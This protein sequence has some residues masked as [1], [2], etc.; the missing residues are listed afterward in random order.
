MFSVFVD[1]LTVQEPG[2]PRRLPNAAELKLENVSYIT[3]LFMSVFMFELVLQAFLNGICSRI[4]ICSLPEY[5]SRR[6]LIKFR[7]TSVVFHFI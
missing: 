2:K 3:E 5:F 4:L 6:K 1:R 7:E